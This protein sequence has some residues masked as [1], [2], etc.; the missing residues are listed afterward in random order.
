MPQEY[1]HQIPRAH[2]DAVEKMASGEPPQ[3]GEM[4]VTL[5]HHFSLIVIIR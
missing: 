3:G 2:L 1:K 5:E 4:R